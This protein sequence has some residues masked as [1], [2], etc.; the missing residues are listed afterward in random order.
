[1]T[2]TLSIGRVTADIATIH[3]IAMLLLDS[4]DLAMIR[5][6]QAMDAGDESTAEIFSTSAKLAQHDIVIIHDAL[7][8]GGYLI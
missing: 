6:Q 4:R 3:S 2:L 1:M 8:A 5:A 7:M